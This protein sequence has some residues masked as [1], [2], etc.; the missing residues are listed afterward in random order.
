VK[1]SVRFEVT[2]H[3]LALAMALDA[4]DAL[5]ELYRG[6]SDPE[7]ES[8]RFSDHVRAMSKP[9]ALKAARIA[10]WSYGEFAWPDDYRSSRLSHS[11]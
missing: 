6:V 7:S 8:P 5:P 10:F 11:A 4:R 9:Q 3:K 1:L 2:A